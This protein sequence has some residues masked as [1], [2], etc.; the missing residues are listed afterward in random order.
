MNADETLYQ[1]IY[2]LFELL[3]VQVG[4]VSVDGRVTAGR[5]SKSRSG[6]AQSEDYSLASW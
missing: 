1:I 4:K 3:D 5:K 6:R 2:P